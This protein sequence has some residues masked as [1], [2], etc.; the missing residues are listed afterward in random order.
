M[1]L[2]S[3]RLAVAMVALLQ[4]MPEHFEKM[5]CMLCPEAAYPMTKLAAEGSTG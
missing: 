5:G 1:M 2:L 3:Q 4:V